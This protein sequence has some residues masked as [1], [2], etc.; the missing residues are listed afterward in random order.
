[1]FDRL[2]RNALILAVAVA[3]FFAVS[4]FSLPSEAFRDL[5]AT[6]FILGALI[7]W[8]L[9]RLVSQPSSLTAHRL[10]FLSA[11]V[12]IIFF[13]SAWRS[14]VPGRALAGEGGEW[15]TVFSLALFL[16][17]FV[18]AALLF[19]TETVRRRAWLAIVFWGGGLWF[20]E[21]VLT[22]LR[23]AHL[24]SRWLP[25]TGFLFGSPGDLAYFGGLI[26]LA[27]LVLLGPYRENLTRRVK[28]LVAAAFSLSLVGEIILDHRAAWLALGIAGFLLFIESNVRLPIGNAYRRFFQ[29]AFV[30]LIISIPLLFGG[31]PTGF[32]GEPLNRLSNFVGWSAVKV[33]PSWSATWQVSY[34]SLL[35]RP[36][37]GPGPN[38]FAIDW[39][40]YR[41]AEPVNSTVFAETD[42]PAGAGTI[43]TFALAGGLLGVLAWFVFL[44]FLLA[45]IVRSG[46]RSWRERGAK[47]FSPTAWS[48]WLLAAPP[49]LYLWTFAIGDWASFSFLLSAAFVSG[50]FL[51]WLGSAKLSPI[52]NGKRHGGKKAMGVVAAGSLV[53]GLLGAVWF[54]ERFAARANLALATD[55]FYARRDVPAAQ[56]ALTSSLAGAPLPRAYRTMAEVNLAALENLLAQP[57]QT[58]AAVR[59]RFQELA[60]AA[61]ANAR[62]AVGRDAE[63]YRNFLVLGAVYRALVPLGFPE[64]Y[65]LA[66]KAYQTAI[67]LAPHLPTIYFER[68]RLALARNDSA[69]AEQWLNAALREKSDHLESVTFLTQLDADARRYDRAALRLEQLISAA[70]NQSRFWYELGW[71]KYQDNRDSE[72]IDALRQAVVIDPHFSNARYFLALSYER[73]GDSAAALAEFEQVLIANPDRADLQALVERLRIAAPSSNG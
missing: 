11:A 34:Q 44:A 68:A 27:G 28:I 17:V 48:G 35:E 5:V 4:F 61:V 58:A 33:R 18:L 30:V 24:T 16:T 8:S 57:D 72:A 42:F 23:L 46:W 12:L 32:I 40:R 64:A 60:G 55:A 3:P 45:A 37:F 50:L 10:W 56:I 39:Q 6:I 1:M 59:L 43:F 9:G 73:S 41:S 2:A 54:I 21:F 69:A 51:A 26:V 29:P 15:G 71:L 14:S 63:D 19:N 62:L 70:P 13:V 22:V 66:E 38:H 36:W 53:L 31:G 49:V 52:W 65:D 20:L 25:P 7:L 47:R 67:S